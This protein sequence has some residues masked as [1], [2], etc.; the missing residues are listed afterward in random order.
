MRT[1]SPSSI[2]RSVAGSPFVAS[3]NTARGVLVLRLVSDQGL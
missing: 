2:Q 3:P 1:K